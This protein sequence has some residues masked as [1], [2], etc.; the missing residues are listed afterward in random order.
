MAHASEVTGL[1]FDMASN[2]LAACNRGGIV[3]LYSLDSMMRLRVIFSFTIN[4]DIPKAIAF[5]QI[6]GDQCNILVFGLYNGQVWVLY[7]IMMLYYKQTDSRSYTFKGLDGKLVN[8]IKTGDLMCMC[9]EEI[10]WND[11]NLITAAMWML[12]L[13]KCVLH[14]Q[15]CTRCSIISPSFW[16]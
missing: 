16:G 3:Q 1:A 9:Y 14:R 8:T 2:Y 12:M 5:G 13:K 11:I 6:G 15:S 7:E 10:K 4:Q